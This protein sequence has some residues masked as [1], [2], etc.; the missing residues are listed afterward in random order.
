M[1]KDLC[2]QNISEP[3]SARLTMIVDEEIKRILKPKEEE[4][5]FSN[6]Q[7]INSQS[8]ASTEITEEVSGSL[9]LSGVSHHANF[10]FHK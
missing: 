8:Q 1:V 2:G 5:R 4:E 7:P 10:T 3:E 9:L 6:Q